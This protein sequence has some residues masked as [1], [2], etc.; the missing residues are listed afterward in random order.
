MP[1]ASGT[2]RRR[3][4][5]SGR[6]RALAPRSSPGSRRSTASRTRRS[7][8]TRSAAA[9]RIAHTPECG[10][11]KGTRIAFEALPEAAEPE[12]AAARVTLLRRYLAAFGPATVADY[13]AWTGL[14]LRD[15]RAAA[16]AAGPLERYADEQG[17]ELLDVPGAVLLPGDT[18]APARLLAR[19]DNI[20]LAYA[21]RSRIVPAQRPLRLD[22]AGADYQVFLVD[23]FVAGRWRLERSRVEL[24]PYTRLS[25]AAKRELA[26][27]STRLEELLHGAR[28][29]ASETLK[30]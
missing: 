12:P 11:W 29:G 9:A 3:G 20:I 13:A 17:R 19:W 5:S 8:G 14:R 6:T 7:T 18:P 10:L 24:A 15:A 27:E 23:G 30:E 16:E 4:A 1:S 2:R 25:R 28:A 26:T 22:D 21:D